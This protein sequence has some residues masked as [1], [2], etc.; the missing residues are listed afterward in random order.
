MIKTEIFQHYDDWLCYAWRLYGAQAFGS[1]KEIK[2]RVAPR[3]GTPFVAL[4]F[5]KIFGLR[6]GFGWRAGVYDGCD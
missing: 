2:G 4:E 5:G 6:V 3:V 1:D